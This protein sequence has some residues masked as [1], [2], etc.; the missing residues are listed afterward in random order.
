MAYNYGLLWLI[1]GLLE[2]I[3]ECCFRLLGFPGICPSKELLSRVK[4]SNTPVTP[5]SGPDKAQLRA[6]R[7][8]FRP[9]FGY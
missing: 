4:E 1:H 8:L 9:H 6:I 7:S 3:L 2:S 5:N